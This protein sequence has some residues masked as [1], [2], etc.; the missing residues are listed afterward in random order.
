MHNILRDS[1]VLTAPGK[2]T[3]HAFQQY[4]MT[5]I[6]KQYH[7][8]RPNFLYNFCL[9][10]FTNLKNTG[11]E[12]RIFHFCS[13]REVSLMCVAVPQAH[14]REGDSEYPQRLISNISFCTDAILVQ[15]KSENHPLPPSSLKVKLKVTLHVLT[16]RI[17]A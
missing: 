10:N 3:R 13:L 7:P 4:G 1:G 16:S 12:G 9:K 5:P 14:Y 17:A 11:G 6:L 8:V 15:S 2:P